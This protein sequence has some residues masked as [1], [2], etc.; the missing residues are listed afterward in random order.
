[1]ISS[2]DYWEWKTNDDYWEWINEDG[3]PMDDIICRILT[4]FELVAHQIDDKI[5]DRIQNGVDNRV[6]FPCMLQTDP[7]TDAIYEEL[8]R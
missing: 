5:R 4:Q 7:L 8:W 3:S 6:M 1:M 2:S